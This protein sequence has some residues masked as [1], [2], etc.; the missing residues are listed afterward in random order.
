[1]RVGIR[2]LI[3]YGANVNAQNYSGECPLSYAVEHGHWIVVMTLLCHDAST[4]LPD[5][6]G[7]T[8]RDL[9]E[10]QG[11][12]N[13]LVEAEQRALDILTQL[14]LE[15]SI[16]RN[17]ALMTVQHIASHIL[18]EIELHPSINFER[19]IRD[20]ANQIEQLQYNA[21]LN[22]KRVAL[23]TDLIK[24]LQLRTNTKACP[25][26][27]DGVKEQILHSPCRW[28]YRTKNVNVGR[29]T[30]LANGI[31]CMKLG[32]NTEACP[33]PSTKMNGIKEQRYSPYRRTYHTTNV[34]VEKATPLANNI[35]YTKLGPSTHL[36]KNLYMISRKE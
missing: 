24:C 22:E 19:M 28:S 29:V 8:V 31:E 3:K 27:M 15:S 1:M 21:K 34:N 13:L 30:S 32:P 36:S 4:L 12:S 17:K 9:A 14:D 26:E 5:Q 35:E 6:C 18:R 25:A 11:I 33:G 7:E 23:I 2:T 20:Q 16:L 10:R